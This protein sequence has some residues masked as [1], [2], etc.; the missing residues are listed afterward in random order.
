MYSHKVSGL[1][2]LNDNK[3]L[4]GIV[5]ESDIFRMIAEDWRKERMMV[6]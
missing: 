6:A 3:E 2:V 1:P 5:T 4:V